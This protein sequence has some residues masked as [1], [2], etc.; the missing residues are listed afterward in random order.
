[1]NRL[2]KVLDLIFSYII[3]LS[4]TVLWL[5]YNNMAL[6]LTL[7]QVLSSI[8]P[9]VAFRQPSLVKHYTNS[10]AI[11][12]VMMTRTTTMT[13]STSSSALHAGGGANGDS[14]NDDVNGNR[15]EKFEQSYEIEV[16]RSPMLLAARRRKQVDRS[17][18]YN[19]QSTPT[20]TTTTSTATGT[21]TTSSTSANINATSIETDNNIQSN[22]INQ[23][24]ARHEEE[25]M[26]KQEEE[27]E[28]CYLDDMLGEV[29]GETCFVSDSSSLSSNDS[30]KTIIQQPIL[31][32]A[33][34]QHTHPPRTHRR[35]PPIPPLRHAAIR[36]LHLRKH[37]HDLRK[38]GRIPE[39]Q[40]LGGGRWRTV[41]G[42]HYHAR[43]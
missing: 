23:K 29:A 10:R 38:D 36:I 16:D 7:L 20:I 22:P 11:P 33:P 19:I 2:E 1:M 9:C 24:S 5:P 3:L 12:Q 13:S 15:E 34:V 32:L 35:S 43:D 31:R 40:Q 41:S 39:S 8:D 30:K 28:L 18:V 4:M 37:R 42:Q 17:N 6:S 27:E 25:T 26:L 14:S 21:T